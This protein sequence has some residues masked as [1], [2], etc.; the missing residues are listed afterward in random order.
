M[1][2]LWLFVWLVQSECLAI[3]YRYIERRTTSKVFPDGHAELVHCLLHG[4]AWRLEDVAAL[5]T[6]ICNADP[7]ALD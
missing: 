2:F 3:I 5:S 1:S 7:S 6:I 4:S